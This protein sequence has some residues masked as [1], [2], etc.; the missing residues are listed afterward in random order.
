MKTY[1]VQLPLIVETKS[2]QEQLFIFLREYIGTIDFD[3]MIALPIY[4][5]VKGGKN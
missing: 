5:N 1:F 3:S 2:Q 4:I